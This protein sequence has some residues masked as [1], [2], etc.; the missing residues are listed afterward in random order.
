MGSIKV[1]IMVRIKVMI[2]G[3]IIVSTKVSIMLIMRKHG[4][5][6]QLQVQA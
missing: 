3:S 6:T 5:L 1:S 2:K 4:C